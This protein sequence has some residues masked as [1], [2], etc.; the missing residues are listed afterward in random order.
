MITENGLLIDPSGK[1]SGRGAYLCKE[2]SCWQAAGQGKILS[3]AL[4][5]PLSENDLMILR[6]Y[7]F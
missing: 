3:Q 7:R 2:Q 1:V 4:K 6:Q 5:S